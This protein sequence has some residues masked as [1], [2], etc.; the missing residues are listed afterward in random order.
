M[1]LKSHEIRVWKATEHHRKV[2]AQ[3]KDVTNER[4]QQVMLQIREDAG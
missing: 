4:T 2:R 1:G 3:K